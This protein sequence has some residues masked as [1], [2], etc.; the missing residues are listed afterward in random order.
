MSAPRVPTIVRWLKFNLV[1]II[2]ACLQMAMLAACIGLAKFPYLPAAVLA[3]EC[4][5]LHNFV[6]HA[7]YLA[8]PAIQ[9]RD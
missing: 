5:I 7:L 1:G 2:G 3:V 6:W 4:T 8:R 9:L